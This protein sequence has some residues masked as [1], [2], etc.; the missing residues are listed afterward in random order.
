[1]SVHG[2]GRRPLC[3]ADDGHPVRLS[4]LSRVLSVVGALYLTWLGVQCLRSKGQL[5]GAQPLQQGSKA[6][7]TGFLTNL[8]NPK[9]MLYFGSILSQEKLN[10]VAR[11][12]NER[13]RKTLNYETSAQRFSQLVAY[14][15]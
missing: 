1:M 11:R 13:P 8:L 12:L 3:E 5:P 10:A 14:T 2:D 6:F 4:E 9:A 7:L 15:G